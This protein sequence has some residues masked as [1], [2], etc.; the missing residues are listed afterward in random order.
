VSASPAGLE[1][2]P[3]GAHRKIRPLLRRDLMEAL[4]VSM[5]QREYLAVQP[6]FG[7]G[8]E[9]LRRMGIFGMKAGFKVQTRTR[10]SES[11][12]RAIDG[13]DRDP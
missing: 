4:S 7:E 3:S 9:A 13:D 2:K 6:M 1:V 8:I 11:K 5:K 12:T 10:G